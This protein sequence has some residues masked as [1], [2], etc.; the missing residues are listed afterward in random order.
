[1]NTLIHFLIQTELM[2]YIEC[3][4]FTREQLCVI[5]NI[6]F[7]RRGALCD[8]ACLQGGM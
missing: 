5:L 3:V 1:V 8:T 4:V 7:Y 6:L 2:T